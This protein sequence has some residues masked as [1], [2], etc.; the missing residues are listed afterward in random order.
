MR[1]IC[2]TKFVR[3]EI[4]LADTAG[5]VFMPY[6]CWARCKNARRSQEFWSTGLSAK[7]ISSGRLDSRAALRVVV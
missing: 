5:R 3:S 4:R 6:V 2:P 1:Q 7:E